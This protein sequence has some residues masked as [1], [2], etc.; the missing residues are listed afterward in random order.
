MTSILSAYTDSLS[1]RAG[2]VLRLYASGPVGPAD[3][4]L[5]RLTR[6][7]VTSPGD[8]DE[9]PWAGSQQIQVQE[10][11]TC[12]GSFMVADLLSAGDARGLTIGMHVWMPHP[13]SDQDQVIAEIADERCSIK[14][15]VR[16]GTFVGEW[17]NG[18]GQT[19]SAIGP[20]VPTRHWAGVIASF[21]DGEVSLDVALDDRADL[22]RASAPAGGFAVPAATQVTFAAR[23]PQDVAA[24]GPLWR[25]RATSH[26]N[27]KIE[28][29]FVAK[30]SLSDAQTRAVLAARDA[31]EIS[32]IDLLGCWDLGNAEP[33]TRSLV[34]SLVG[35]G[36]ARLVNLPA[37]AVTGRLWDGR[38]VTY[39]VEPRLWN[40]VHFHQDDL[41]DSGWPVVLEAALPTDI[42]SGLYGIRVSSATTTDI[43]PIVIRPTTT[44]RAITV[45]I[46]TFT[47]LAYANE[48]LYDDL[49]HTLFSSEPLE[50]NDLDRYRMETPEVGLSQY[51]R[52][53]DT[54]GVMFSTARRPILNMRHDQLMWLSG[55]ARHLAAEMFL[56]EWLIQGGFE[57]DVI[58]DMELQEMGADALGDSRVLI[59]GSHPEYHTVETMHAFTD[60]RDAGGRIMYLGANGF[61]WVTGVVSASPLVTEVRRGVAGSRSWESYP[62]EDTLQSTGEP[63][64]LWRHRG[65]APNTVVGIGIVAQ[66]WGK[67]EPYWRTPESY[68]DAYSWVFDGVDEE[69][70]GAYGFVMGGAA[71]DELDRF[72]PSLGSP[73]NTVVLA[74]SRD[75]TRF[76]QRVH[77]ELAFTLPGN[78]GDEDPAVRADMVMVETPGGGRVFSVGSI[79][80]SGA[81]L[82]NGGDN[83]ISRLTRNVLQRFLST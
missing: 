30:G 62:G 79:A 18:A 76:Y 6:N 64:G 47:Y 58:T 80:Y 10:Q 5:V 21:T 16:A 82:V 54:S 35:D 33:G 74:S 44:H 78:G 56:I 20:P 24:T 8:P 23:A 49:D 66:G 12:I 39:R 9:V 43:V 63:G 75:H 40:A 14:I 77:E 46:P 51:D 19:A 70:I 45:L 4:T 50:M 73:I 29:P 15:L 52:H 34:P 67:S 53:W 81:L 27:G 69:P 1:Y 72:D 60:F 68:S 42:D 71:G 59:T 2:D 57:F 83:G 3:V 41:I 65:M 7:I 11:P 55:S 36:H 32:G 13:E 22:V 48:Q 37:S 26:F 17:A 28:A 31:V 25:G 61:Y 38:A